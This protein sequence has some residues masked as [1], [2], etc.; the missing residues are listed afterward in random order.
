MAVL[1]LSFGYHDSAAVVVD[2]EGRVV[3]AAQEEQFSRKK[4]DRGFPRLAIDHVCRVFGSRDFATVAYYENVALKFNR[5]VE[6]AMLTANGLYLMDAMTMWLV[7]DKFDPARTIRE[8]LGRAEVVEFSHHA[9]HIAS[10]FYCSPFERA[11]ILTMDGVGEYE[12]LTV[13][14]GEG[15]RIEKIAVLHLPL[16]LGLF[17]SAITAYL[18]FEVNEGEYKVMGMA[19][20]GEPRHLD[21]MRKLIWPTADGFFALDERY[22]QFRSARDVPYT[23]ALVELLGPARVPDSPFRAGGEGD[24]RRHADIAASAQRWIEELVCHVVLGAVRR[25]GVADVCLAGGVALNSLANH[26]LQT[27]MTGRL[28]VQP[29]AGDAGGAMGA[30]LLAHHITPGRRRAPPLRVPYLGDQFSEDEI[31]SILER[32]EVPHRRLADAAETVAEVAG[33]LAGGAVVGWV[34]GRVEWGP[35]AL[36]NRSILAS[37]L[38]ARMQEVV[39]T[40]IKFREPFRPFAPAVIKER[41]AEFFE[42]AAPLHECGPEHYM[43]SVA[44]VRPDK[45]AL[46][47]AVTHV[48]GTARLQAVDRDI[49]PMFHALIEEFGRLTGVPVLLNTSF[50]LKGEPIVRSPEDALR[51]FAYSGMDALVLGHHLIAKDGLYD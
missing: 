21:A 7:E 34:Q 10:A 22:F 5:I 50:N 26:R 12:T 18:G 39:N 45:R 36:G 49:N 9:S 11:T 41:A 32:H 33:L 25:T 16:S 38:D 43:L 42:L 29:A 2:D 19:G 31:A 28:Y 13:S 48:D 51:T 4:H 30:A 35:R 27:K 14:I 24:V 8:A 46:I 40:K 15:S 3:A 37:P 20:F 44:P 47:P 17:Y 23:P 6:S 1:G